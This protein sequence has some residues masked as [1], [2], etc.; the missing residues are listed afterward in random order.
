MSGKRK[1]SG[2]LPNAVQS[3]ISVAASAS[4]SLSFVTSCRFWLAANS[5]WA[6][7]VVAAC[8]PVGMRLRMVNLWP[9]VALVVFLSACLVIRELWRGAGSS[10][11]PGRISLK[12]LLILALGVAGTGFLLWPCLTKGAFVSTAGD[13]FMYSAYGQ[14]VAD[15]HRG[16]ELFGLSPVDQYG[17]VLS[18]HRF[19][20][21]SILSFFSLLFHSTTAEALPIFAFIVLVNIF[22]GF[23]V[24]GR[25]FGCNRLCSLAA[26]LL[27]VIGG[28]TSNALHIGALDNLLFL[29]L[30]PFLVVRLELY[31][32]GSKAWSTSLGLAIVAAA[33]FYVYPEGLSIAAVIFLPFFCQSVWSGMYRRGG[34]WRRYVISGCLA[35]VLIIPCV[36]LFFGSMFQHVKLGL[37]TGLVG[38]VFPGLLSPRFLPALFGFGQEYK[39]TTCSPHDLVLPISMLAFIALG[40]AIW[41][42]RRKTLVMAFLILIMMAIWQGLLV[43]DD[44][45]LYKVLFIGALIWIPAL[46]LGGTAVANIVPRPMRPFAV[47]LGAIFF[48]SGALAQRMEQQKQMLF[49]QVIPM[50]WYSDLAGLRHKVGNRPVLLVC[51]YVFDRENAWF[52]QD[53]ALFFLRRVNLKVPQYI[54]LDAAYGAWMQLAKSFSE[55]A[56]FVL[57]NKHM[58]GA[59]WNNQRF[60]LLELPV[61]AKVIGVQAPNGVEQVNGKPFVWLGKNATRF[62]I[63]SKIAQTANFSAEE[64]LTGSTR[65]EDKNREVRISIGD[66]VWQADVSGALSLQLPLK[67]GLNIL[68]IARQDPPATSSQA[69]GDTKP[70][71]FGLWDYRISTM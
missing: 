15:H 64:C 10:S 63:V 7:L 42:R 40:S 27:A 43:K 60:S 5:I 50:K 30:F 39:E 20:T 19:G 17:A 51:D 46:F 54:G 35:L 9:L 52:D 33:V 41:I 1:F 61:Q 70:V 16:V 22:S 12:T 57:V 38:V 45:G 49:R 21:A 62:L 18:W 23:V 4:F 66:N 65:S 37:G 67:P 53:W 28:W 29:S 68:D 26:G 6:T 8:I 13:T 47:A 31:R 58:E 2:S 69:S 36:E 44:Y 34:A 48:F 14:Y 71:P 32:L 59:L 25:R 55:P 11:P 24:L 56:A 3:R